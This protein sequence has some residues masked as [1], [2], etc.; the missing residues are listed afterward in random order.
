MCTAAQSFSPLAACAYIIPPFYFAAKAP[1]TCMQHATLRKVGR[2]IFFYQKEEAIPMVY[3]T[4]GRK[5]VVPCMYVYVYACTCL[6]VSHDRYSLLSF[7]QG[8]V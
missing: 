4:D 7:L 5:L 8:I 6:S 2:K 3:N 1:L